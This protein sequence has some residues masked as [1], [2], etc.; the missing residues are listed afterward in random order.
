[1]DRFGSE[2]PPQF[3]SILITISTE[4]GRN[5]VTTL[6]YPVS[7]KGIKPDNTKIYIVRS[8]SSASSKGQ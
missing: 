5:T 2:M 8:I 4:Y 7:L 1:M 3:P 6:N